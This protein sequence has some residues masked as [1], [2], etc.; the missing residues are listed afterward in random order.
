MTNQSTLSNSEQLDEG[1]STNLNGGLRVE[2]LKRTAQSAVDGNNVTNTT[3][4]VSEQPAPPTEKEIYNKA[5]ANDY[6]S[7]KHEQPAPAKE[8]NT[9]IGL[10]PVVFYT[11]LA[12]LAIGVGGFLYWKYGMKKPTVVPTT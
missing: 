7:Q 1:V 9:I 12:V 11:G 6:D 8:E 4:K 2:R 5:E 3:Q 10:K